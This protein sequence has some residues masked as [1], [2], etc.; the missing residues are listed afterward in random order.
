MKLPRPS[1]VQALLLISCIGVMVVLPK[2]QS[3]STGSATAVQPTAP[4]WQ[5]AAGGKMAFDVASVKQNVSG[6]PPPGVLLRSA[7]PMDS[8][9]AYIPTGGLFSAANFPLDAYITF[10]YKLTPNQTQALR[11][12]LPK[13]ATQDRFDIE[14]RGA[15]NPTKDQM[16]LMMQSLLAGRFKLAVHTET[17]QL[18]VFGLILVKTGTTGPRLRPHLDDPPC[19]SS[20]TSPPAPGSTQPPPTEVAGGFP[21]LCDFVAVHRVSGYTHL[22]ARHMTIGMIANLMLT[23]LLNRPVLDQ[24]GLSGYFDFT[25]EY[26][27]ISPPPAPSGDTVTPDPTRP[28]FLEALKEQLGLKLESQT[29]PVDVIV[30]DH[31]EE[32]SPN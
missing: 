24:T 17:R 26:T 13:W 9:D 25:L 3:Q 16:R 18:P 12:D 11:P 5:I 1:V 10:A 19:A 29:G 7:V 8:G 27:P 14:A 30:V 20:S 23:Q 21:T 32:P 31:I 4:Q 28:T 15:G 22:G 6:P 2:L